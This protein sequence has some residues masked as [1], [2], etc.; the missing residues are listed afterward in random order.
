MGLTNKKEKQLKTMPVIQ[1]RIKTSR[2]GRFVIQQTVITNV[3]PIEYYKAILAN[4]VKVS[5]EPLGEDELMIEDGEEMLKR[6]KA[7]A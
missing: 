7:T 2:N 3:K 4:T 1:N 6:V 5:E